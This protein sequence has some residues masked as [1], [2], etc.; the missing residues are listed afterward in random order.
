MA[1]MVVSAIDLIVTN[2]LVFSWTLFP[3]YPTTWSN[4]TR[5]N[6][7]HE[8]RRRHADNVCWK[9]LGLWK[10]LDNERVFTHDSTCPIDLTWP[11]LTCPDLTYP[12]LTCPDCTCPELTCLDLTC[13]NF[14]CPDLTCPDLTL[15]YPDLTCHESTCTDSTCPE[16]ICSDMTCPGLVPE[17]L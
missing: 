13:P 6:S 10:F 1:N 11:D 9:F 3:D 2:S 16:L 14:T 12:D 4:P 15:T 5:R 8:R 7:R 17:T